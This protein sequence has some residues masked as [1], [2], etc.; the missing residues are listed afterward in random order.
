MRGHRVNGWNFWMVQTNTGVVRLSAL[1]DELVKMH[2][3]PED[4]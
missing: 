1:R 4:D 2:V 3:H